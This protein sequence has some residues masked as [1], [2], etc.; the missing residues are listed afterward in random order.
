MGDDQGVANVI[1]APKEAQGHYV[2][3]RKTCLALSISLRLV[4]GP[5]PAVPTSCHWLHFL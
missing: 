5:A 2:H 3:Y 4:A 1:L